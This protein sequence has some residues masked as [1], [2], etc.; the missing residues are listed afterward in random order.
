MR[1]LAL[2]CVLLGLGAV[3]GA[4]PAPAASAAPSAVATEETVDRFFTEAL[5]HGQAYDQL[6]S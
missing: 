2:L 6:P 5:E 4:Q 3:A 1:P